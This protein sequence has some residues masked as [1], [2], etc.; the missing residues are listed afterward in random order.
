[1]HD[2]QSIGAGG[3]PATG[4]VHSVPPFCREAHRGE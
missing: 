1:M 4:E 3:V 2:A